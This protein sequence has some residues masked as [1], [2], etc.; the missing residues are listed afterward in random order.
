MSDDQVAA[1]NRRILHFPVTLN[2]VV[3]VYNLPQRPELRFGGD[4]LAG[5]FLGKITRWDDPAIA[6]DNPGVDLPRLDIKVAHLNDGRADTD[7][8]A[9][10][11]QKVSPAF[12][13]A[14]ANS[15]GWTWPAANGMRGYKGAEGVPQ[16]IRETPGAIGYLA[17]ALARFEI[18]RN[19]QSPL[20]YAAVKN[21]AGDFVTASS[22]SLTA[23]GATAVA[24]IQAQVPDFRVLI[25]NAPGKTS[26]PIASF[27]WLLVHEDSVE[28]KQRE[29]MVDFLKWVL[30][31]GQEQALELG[32]PPLPSN[33]VKIELKCLDA[34]PG[35]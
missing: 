19:P 8:I 16:I 6:N 27:V 23:A 2:A 30:T 21:S 3:P 1:S 26:Y 29:V 33:L 4:T 14:L 32:Y 5:I 35:A 18:A 9:D 24:A 15:P 22:E 13:M 11:L 34:L 20:R 17:L 25:T 12:A 28:T 31:D 7:V 10:Y